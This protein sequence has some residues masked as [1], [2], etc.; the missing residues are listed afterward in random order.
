MEEETVD[1][2]KEGKK[3]ERSKR[4]E[5]TVRKGRGKMEEKCKEGREEQG[6]KEE[7]IGEGRGRLGR[8]DKRNRDTEERGGR[9]GVVGRIIEE[10]KVSKRREM[11]G[12][13]NY[14]KDETRQRRKIAER[15]EGE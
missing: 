4:R 5:S 14:C 15:K 3:G 7:A 10:E 12:R 1:E 8:K 13:K 9:E 2:R 11:K 6:N